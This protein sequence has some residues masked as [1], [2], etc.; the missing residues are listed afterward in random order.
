MKQ[1]LTGLP[2]IY[3]DEKFFWQ[4]DDTY[5]SDAAWREHID[6]ESWYQKLSS[7]YQLVCKL[8]Q[9]LRG[10]D[11]LLLQHELRLIDE[12]K[13]RRDFFSTVKR[14]CTL[15]SPDFSVHANFA[16]FYKVVAQ[17]IAQDDVNSVSYPFGGIAIW[18]ILVTEQVAR[19]QRLNLPLQEALHLYGPDDGLDNLPEDWGGEVRIPY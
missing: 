1:P 14:S 12:K 9:R 13:H 17:I 4:G 19:S 6:S 16:E 5:L 18:R 10:V 8:Q 7:L 2:F 11:D 15:K 3:F